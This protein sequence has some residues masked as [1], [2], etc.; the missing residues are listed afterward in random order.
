[1]PVL[2]GTAVLVER[3]GP[4]DEGRRDH[5][6]EYRGAT[7][8]GPGYIG[9]DLAPLGPEFPAYGPSKAYRKQDRG[10]CEREKFWRDVAV[11]EGQ[12]TSA[13][14]KKS[15]EGRDLPPQPHDLRN[16]EITGPF[17]DLRRT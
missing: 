11:R 10:R 15:I 13:K 8:D 12:G 6:G 3:Y 5:T 14:A 1:M 2:V 7:Q 4:R 16:L 9:R 17:S